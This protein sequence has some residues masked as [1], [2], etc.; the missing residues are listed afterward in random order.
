VVLPDTLVLK[1]TE[2]VPRAVLYPQTQMVVD[3]F[4]ELFPRKESSA[5]KRALPVLYDLRAEPLQTQAKPALALIMTTIKDYPDIT[6]K[7]ISLKNPHYL[8]VILVYRERER[9]TVKFPI[10][11]DYRFL[12][13]TLQSTILKNDTGKRVIDLQ[14]HGKVIIPCRR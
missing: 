2:R 3:E 14:Y 13:N 7:S 5:A 12:L 11:E 8:L 1:L 4:G 6:I 9:Y 10:R